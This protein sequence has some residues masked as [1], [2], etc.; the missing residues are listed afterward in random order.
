MATYREEVINPGDAASRLAKRVN[1]ESYLNS[2]AIRVIDVEDSTGFRN[3]VGFVWYQHILREMLEQ[4]TNNGNWEIAESPEGD[5]NGQKPGF[6]TL[7][8]TPE[9]F[10]GQGSDL[11]AMNADDEARSGRF[12]VAM[13]S[14][15]ID[16]KRVT[17]SNF[18]LVEAL[19]HGYA[20]QLRR[21]HLVSMTGEFAV[22]KY[23]ITAFCDLNS[24]EQLILT[25]SA[26][27]LGLMRRSKLIN[28]ANI[29]PGMPLVGFWEKS[30]RCNGGGRHTQILMERHGGRIQDML[31]DP[32][33]RNFIEKLA[34][35][36]QSYAWALSRAHGW[37]P[38]GSVGEPHATIVGAGHI[39]GGG[40]FGKFGENLPEGVGAL[41]DQMPVPCDVLLQAQQ[42]SKSTPHPMADWECHDTFHGGCGMLVACR[43]Y[44]NAKAL[45]KSV[46]EEGV[47]ASIVGKTVESNDRVVTVHSRFEEGGIL[48]SNEPPDQ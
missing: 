11:V 38:D 13:I 42:L 39:T 41:L 40:L 31:E 20:D 28:N 32:Q 2:E 44:S 47:S 24:D 27:C 4:D 7:V 9:A 8:G 34:I 6:Y 12:A 3:P 37:L 18:H 5:G 46:K 16:A 21:S 10:Y 22:M 17:K 30:Y 25:W 19:F 26:A 1:R 48:R 45:I 36:S 15:E 43:D 35:P 23:A 33:T 29:R 14:N